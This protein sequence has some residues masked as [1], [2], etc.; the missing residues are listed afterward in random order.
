MERRKK[1]LDRG[2]GSWKID[3]R[4]RGGK[5]RLEGGLGRKKRE[6]GGRKER[7]DAEGE[8]KK[9]TERK[10]EREDEEEE[11]KNG[12]GT[13]KE[14]EEGRQFEIAKC[15][16]CYPTECRSEERGELRRAG[17]ESDWCWRLGQGR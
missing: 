15:Q 6:R 4:R 8:L 1:T 2:T 16:L 5:G 11:E 9:K 12:E 13:E 10:R 14:G 7:K 17:S 3:T